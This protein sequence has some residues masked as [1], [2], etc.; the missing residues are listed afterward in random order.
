MAIK[1]LNI[2]YKE[3]DPDRWLK[4]DRYLRRI[5]RR[6]VRGKSRI[7][8]V[9][10]IALNLL[11]GLEKLS[12]P[13]RYNDFKYIKNHPAEIACII[14]KPQLL[15]EH[16]WANPIIYGAGIFSHPVADPDLLSRHPNIRKILVPGPWVRDMFIQHFGEHMVEAW[17]AGID[18]D[19][20]RTNNAQK[21]VD[22]LVYSKFLWDK[23]ANA[24]KLLQPILTHLDAEKL[25]YKIITYGSYK[26]TDLLDALNSCRTAIFLCEHESQ[27]FAYQQ[28]LSSGV[29][30]FAWDRQGPW[31]DPSFYPHKVVF[32]PASSVP[33]WDQRCGMKFKD[34]TDFYGKLQ[35]FIQAAS[36]GQFDPRSFVV[37][38]LSLEKS[39]NQYLKIVKS[40]K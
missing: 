26:H 6:V 32:T 5:I 12:I 34:L 20:W 8:S 13:Y 3:P 11:A 24:Q 29:P 19:K 7:G 31:L 40:V 15:E 9:E 17:P 28:I 23:E 22:V 35:I 16:K 27:G 33:Y 10:M 18:I 37:D 38:N 39:A 21:A 2:F 14:G 4:Y 30:I 36:E 1:P 25:S